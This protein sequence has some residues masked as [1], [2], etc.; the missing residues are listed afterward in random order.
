M[1]FATEVKKEILGND[2]NNDTLSAFVAGVMQGNVET[3]FK[4]SKLSLR[5]TSFMP[6]LIRFLVPYFKK[7][8]GIN[9]ETFYLDRTNINKRR[10]YFININDKVQEIME[11]FKIYPFYTIDDKDPIFKNDDTKKA[12]TAGC[13]VSK[14][15]I[16]DPRKSSYHFEILF[17]Q[18]E[19]AELVAK[20]MNKSYIK[21]S[22]IPKLNQ[23]LLYIKKSEQI[24]DALRFIGADS[25]V[26][27]FEDYRI[28]R[29]MNNSVNRAMNCDIAN[30]KR[31]LE[32]CQNQLKA[33]KYLKENDLHKKMSQRLQDAMHLREIYPDSTLAELSEYSEKVIGKHLSK[34][35]ISHC[36]SEIME[37]YESIINKK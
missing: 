27:Q 6:S 18:I 32:Y 5:I 17:K 22:I 29:D 34:S 1:S 26:L 21:P 7:R 20:F 14:G 9:L 28:M 24:S 33:I 8:Y 31:S 13:F 35:G 36:M 11:D 2:F 23:Y 10:I 12:F 16:S 15:S 30:Y 19:T 4:D 3:V 37:Y 25:G